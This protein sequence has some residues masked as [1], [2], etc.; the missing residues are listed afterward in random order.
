MGIFDIKPMGGSGPTCIFDF[1]LV[2][3][4]LKSEDDIVN[5]LPEKCREQ[6]RL[7]YNAKTPAR[8]GI[9]IDYLVAKEIDKTLVIPGIISLYDNL[10]KG[11]DQNN[12]STYDNNNN[13][14]I[15]KE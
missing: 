3:L 6:A 5:S 10:S 2:K 13:G 1:N 14:D 9:C 15:T 4:C 12:I 7:D 8:V 11:L